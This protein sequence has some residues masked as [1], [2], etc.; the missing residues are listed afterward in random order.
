VDS[1]DDKMTNPLFFYSDNRPDDMVPGDYLKMIMN[2]FKETSSDSFRVQ[3]LQNGLATNSVAEEWFDGLDPATRVNWNLVEAAFKMRWPRQVLVDQTTKQRRQ[4]L[5]SEKLKKDDIGVMVFSNGVEMTGQACWANKIQSLA[6]LAD[7][8]TGALIHSVRET[9][10]ALMR[11]LVKGLF[12]T[13]PRFCAAI[14]AVSD[15]EIESA[16]DEERR[17]G[18]VEEELKKL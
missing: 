14:K 15:E 6:L 10:P 5:C 17:I 16:V 9:M 11:K 8:P 12:D 18:T 2:M 13:W 1:S 4:H 7:N 3:R